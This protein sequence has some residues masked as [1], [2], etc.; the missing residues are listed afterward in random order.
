MSDIEYG[1][2]SRICFPSV[3]LRLFDGPSCVGIDAW[4]ILGHGLSDG[5]PIVGTITKPAPGLQPEPFGKVRFDFWEG[6]DFVQY[7]ELQGDQA[8][9]RTG[10]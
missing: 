2:V 1:K 5:V 3:R 9:C 10:E 7:D 4:R 8:S 6:S